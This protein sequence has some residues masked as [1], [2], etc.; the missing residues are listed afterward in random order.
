MIRQVQPK[1]RF[2]VFR[3]GSWYHVA[4]HCRSAIRLSH[5]PGYKYADLGFRVSL[6]LA[7]GAGPTPATPKQI[8]NS[9]GLCQTRPTGLWWHHLQD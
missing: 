8:T 1:A 5:L 7:E 6:V 9:I 3:G 2:R 4:R